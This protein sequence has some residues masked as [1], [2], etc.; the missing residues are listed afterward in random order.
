[1]GSK[2][3]TDPQARLAHHAMGS[4]HKFD[5]AVEYGKFCRTFFGMCR[6]W[7]KVPS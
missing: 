5:M 1:M 3:Y 4:W 2:A 7:T 6:D